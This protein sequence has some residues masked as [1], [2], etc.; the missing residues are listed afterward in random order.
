MYT[1]TEMN[2]KVRIVVCDVCVICVC[3]RFNDVTGV[4]LYGIVNRC[5]YV[6]YGRKLAEIEIE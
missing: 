2:V 5:T 3:Y 4:H 1:C 6:R